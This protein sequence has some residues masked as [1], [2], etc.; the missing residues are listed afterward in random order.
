[1]EEGV[2]RLMTPV[3]KDPPEELYQVQVLVVREV[4]FPILSNTKL[5]LERWG[6]PPTLATI[7]P[8]GG[9]L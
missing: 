3:W 6:V 5:K 1:M 8:Q 4:I 9:L 2:Q 7:K